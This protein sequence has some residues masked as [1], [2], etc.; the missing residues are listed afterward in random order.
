M[1][2]PKYTFNWKG[3][4]ALFA[5]GIFA[6]LVLSVVAVG[7]QIILKKDI[8]N[9]GFFSIF[10]LAFMW[11]AV[12]AAFDYFVCRPETGKKLKFNFSSANF[13][14][15]FLIF[16]MMFGMMLIGDFAVSQI[17]TTGFFFEEYYKFF[18]GLM[19][20]LT[21]NTFV[22]IASVVIVAP[23]FEEIVFRGIIQKGLI[24]GGMKPQSAIWISSLIFGL[25]HGN[26][27]QFAGAVLLG[28]VLGTVYHKT[29]SLLLPI[30]LHFFN[31]LISL[32]LLEFS[33]SESFAQAFHISEWLTLI[34]GIAI[35]SVFYYF[36]ITKYKSGNKTLNI[37]GQTH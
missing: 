7:F 13:Y 25:V 19:K 27:W 9:S 37:A 33:S 35:F 14:T 8:Q 20:E 22:M 24:N 11:I 2:L 18:S 10:S 31:N 3:A 15:Y 5:G 23:I 26:P 29:K 34:I 28:F 6:T 30:L 1:N 21:K 17:P 36:F 32:M 12:V 16:P 4:V